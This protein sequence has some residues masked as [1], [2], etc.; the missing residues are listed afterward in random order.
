MYNKIVGGKIMIIGDLHFSDVFTGK[1]KNYLENCFWVLGKI[2]KKI[3]ETKPS[4]IVLGG[5]LIGWTET[6]VKDRQVLS[7]FCKVLQS[8]ND[9]CPVYSVKG[10]HDI[11][12]YPDFLFLS[13]LGLIITSA[14]CGGYFD[15]YG[16]EDQENPEVR[17]HF[18]DYGDEDKALNILHAE[19]S[20]NIVLGHNNYTIQGITTW[21]SDHDGK[22][23]GM[24]QNFGDV[25]MVISGHIHNPSPEIFST[26]MP[27]GKDC[28]LF[29]T[30]CP[31][32]PI[33]EKNLYESCWY[34]FVEYNNTTKSTDINTDEFKLLPAKEVFYDDEDFVD[35][36]SE[37]ELQEGI[38]KEKLTEVLGDLL[39]Y[40]ISD[41]DPIKQIQNIPHASPEAKTIA[42]QYLTIAINQASS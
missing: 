31:T 9:V 30:G 41:G 23:L 17:F 10:N 1:H 18:V 33:K 37:E 38:R 29:Y 26:Q 39:K 36:K 20:S 5:D 12:G 34:V 15:Y 22:E 35:D 3:E 4:A 13:E 27:S 16:T 6:N 2:S 28:M 25:D 21:Y 14:E 42:T 7:M 40:R 11:K 24:M 8:W 19:G 32:R